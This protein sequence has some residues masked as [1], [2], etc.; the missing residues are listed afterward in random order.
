MKTNKPKR[1]DW[2]TSGLKQ[3]R[4]TPDQKVFRVAIFM[5]LYKGLYKSVF[6]HCKV[7]LEN[8]RDCIFVV[9]RFS[10]NS[11]DQSLLSDAA[12]RILNSS[13]NYN[14]V[15]SIG[16][17][18]SF[19]MRGKTQLQTKRTPVVFT[20]VENSLAS[21][22][23]HARTSSRN[24][25]V[26]VTVVTPCQ[27]VPIQLLREANPKCRKFFIPYREEGTS[28]D[29]LDNILKC[30]AAFEAE[31]CIVTPRS[32]SGKCFSNDFFDEMKQYAAVVIPEG[33]TTIRDR[34]T[35]ISFCNGANIAVHA[36]G[37]EAIEK[38]ALFATSSDVRLM[39]EKTV[40]KVKK[41][42]KE[43]VKPSEITT[44]VMTK[45]RKTLYGL[46]NAK[47][48]GVIFQ[49]GDYEM[50]FEP[51]TSGNAVILP[52]DFATKK[53]FITYCENNSIGLQK[54]IEI[55]TQH[56]EPE[57]TLYIGTED[58]TSFTTC[59][60]IAE[61]S[62]RERVAKLV[63]ENGTTHPPTF[64]VS[65]GTALANLIA[66]MKT[67]GRHRPITSVQFASSLEQAVGLEESLEHGFRHEATILEP[68]DP[69]WALSYLKSIG[70]SGLKA[71]YL[72]YGERGQEKRGQFDAYLELCCQVA[73]KLSFEV[74]PVHVSSVN[75]VEKVMR[76]HSGKRN[77]FLSM[78]HLIDDP[79]AREMVLM[80]RRLNLLILAPSMVYTHLSPLCI[81]MEQGILRN[82][83]AHFEQCN[84]SL[85]IRSVMA[86]DLYIRYANE[87][88]LTA[89][90]Y[91]KELHELI[92]K[93]GK[94]LTK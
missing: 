9:D 50:S 75:E 58:D 41:I 24:N 52:P 18:A 43:G 49:Q 44:T 14:A 27:I 21:E 46:D 69:T 65:G 38:G 31:G 60:V 8:D 73:N 25:L 55:L 85:F 2:R 15:I 74:R 40:E 88:L 93:S 45:M 10:V 64:F 87:K 56:V 13:M 68:V 16:K 12:D 5:P 63:S 83:G 17:C 3:T 66:E 48:L 90:G 70:R 11:V 20:A 62:K 37:K 42:V 1:H 28:E 71:A 84:E 34:D 67:S 61:E 94:I 72:L 57:L 29:M 76:G 54:A 81:G 19:M 78:A 51:C 47:R 86:Q 36:D 22:L 39:A 59:D 6:N 53:S 7:A 77:A 23:I 4:K 80:G 89:M 35:I 26:G 91:K 79:L 30:K 92:A 32:F 33:C 82:E